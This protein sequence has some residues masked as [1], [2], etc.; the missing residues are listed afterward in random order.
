MISN[1]AGRLAQKQPPF[2]ECV[3]AHLNIPAFGGMEIL[4]LKWSEL[5]SLPKTEMLSTQVGGVVEELPVNSE[6]RL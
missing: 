5:K 4:R 1:T 2:K 6:G 3:T